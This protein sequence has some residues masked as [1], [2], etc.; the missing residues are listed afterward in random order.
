MSEA[1]RKLEQTFRLS[2]GGDFAIIVKSRFGLRCSFI[3]SIGP[4][5]FPFPLKL[6]FIFAQ[7][8]KAYESREILCRSG[9]TETSSL[10]IAQEGV[11]NQSKNR[12]LHAVRA[13]DA[14]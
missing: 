2:E 9:R 7:A 6:T 10:N 11:Q 1:N 4:H 12:P 8:A 14:A 3:A 13:G 5:R